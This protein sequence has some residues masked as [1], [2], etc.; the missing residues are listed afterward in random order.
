MLLLHKA[1]Q[2]KAGASFLLTDTDAELA[3]CGS[4]WPYSRKINLAEQLTWQRMGKGKVV[5][6]HCAM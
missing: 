3:V 2:N 6:R 5:A 4:W 1:M